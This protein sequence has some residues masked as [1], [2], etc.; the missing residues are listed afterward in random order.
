VPEIAL[1][2]EP[3]EPTAPTMLAWETQAPQYPP[4]G[5][6]G[7]SYYPGRTPLGVIDCLLWRNEAG[8]VVG[9]LNHYNFQT[10]EGQAAGSMNI[11]VKP[12]W[13]RRGI[14]TRLAD[15]ARRRWDIDLVHQSYTPEGAAAT[16]RW[17]ERQR[18]KHA[19]GT[20]S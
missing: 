20:N 11:W 17:A 6:P 14:A 16:M 18:R 5:P 7:V 19:D 3:L 13:Q 15:E 1:P 8:E 10:P 9:I 2:D 12:E 4:S